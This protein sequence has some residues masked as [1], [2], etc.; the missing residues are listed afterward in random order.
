MVDMYRIVLADDHREIRRGLRAL[1]SDNRDMEVIGEAGDGAEAIEITGR[2]RPDVL[3]TDLKMPRYDG[4]DVTRRVR[5]LS[6][7]TVIIIFSLYDGDVYRHAALLAGAA[8]FLSKKTDNHILVDT[9]RE[10]TPGRGGP[11]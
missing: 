4:V 11:E 1:L 10:V 9:I 7:E 5:V 6:P 2:L 8:R 3:I